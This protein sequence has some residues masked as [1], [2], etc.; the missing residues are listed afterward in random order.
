VAR[1]LSVT[2]RV[3]GGT[4]LPL[5]VGVHGGLVETTDVGTLTI[6]GGVVGSWISELVVS[7]EGLLQ[8]RMLVGAYPSL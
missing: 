7:D 6:S 5:L 4:H 8:P 2:P 3:D 1:L